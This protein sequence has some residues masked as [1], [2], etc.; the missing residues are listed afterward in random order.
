[1]YRIRIFFDPN[2]QLLGATQL[3]A[4]FGLIVGFAPNN[5]YGEVELVKVVT[6]EE[7]TEFKMFQLSLYHF[8]LLL[9]VVACHVYIQDFLAGILVTFI[10]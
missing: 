2:I 6:E 3:R 1:M 10:F 8:Q 7:K 9:V 5:R 4:D